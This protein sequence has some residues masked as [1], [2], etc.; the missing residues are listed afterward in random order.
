MY[1]IRKPLSCSTRCTCFHVECV[2]CGRDRVGAKF[3]K[4]QLFKFF[5]KFFSEH[6]ITWSF[7][8]SPFLPSTELFD[9]NSLQK[10][11]RILAFI[12]VPNM[13]LPNWGEDFRNAGK[14]M[15]NTTMNLT[16]R[17]MQYKQMQDG[18]LP[19][20]FIAP[21]CACMRPFVRVRACVRACMRACITVS[22]RELRSNSTNMIVDL[23][24]TYMTLTL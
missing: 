16:W 15:N 11:R 21:V 9:N 7:Y 4:N 5:Q 19:Y 13:D 12:V 8:N 14:G 3:G 2:E 10:P 6:G 24:S 18:H 20:N 22:R 17:I 1:I 23:L